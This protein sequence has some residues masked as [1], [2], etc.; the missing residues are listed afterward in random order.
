M[1]LKTSFCNGRVVWK[2]LTRFAPVWALYSVAAILYVM[3]LGSDF[4]YMARDLLANLG[5]MAIYRF[6]HA[7]IVAAC[8]FGD[9]FDSRMCNGL[10]AMPIRRS[11]WLWTN[12]ISGFL[13][14]LIPAL[15]G[16]A[17]AALLLGE[18][19]WVVLIW[20]GT[21]LLFF[22]FFYAVAVFSAMCAGKRLGMMAI[23][24]ILNFA[25]LLVY[26]VIATIYEP[27]LYGVVL[28]TTWFSN[29]CPANLL[30]SQ[31]YVELADLKMIVAIESWNWEAWNCLAICTGVGIVIYALSFLLYCKRKLETAGDFLSF[32]TVR[33][34]FML[35]YTLAV[36]I[37]IFA[38]GNTFQENH[39]YWFLALG[40]TIGYFTGRMLLDRTVKVFRPKVL[41]GFVIVGAL[42]AGSIGLSIWDPLGVQS[43][44]PP[45]EQIVSASL[46][47]EGNRSYLD[48]WDNWSSGEWV[49]MNYSGWYITDPA[50][51]DQVR[52]FHSR[53]VPDPHTNP[54]LTNTVNVQYQLKN[55]MVIR[56]CYEMP[57][58]SVEAKEI[59]DF[60]IA[61]RS[62]VGDRDWNI[63]AENIQK[64]QI[65]GKVGVR[66]CEIQNAQQ[67]IAL[68]E[69]L[70]LDAQAGTII[71]SAQASYNRRND[72]QVAELSV[73]WT[74]PNE[75]NEV[76]DE[77]I[78]IYEDYV[79]TVAFLESLGDIS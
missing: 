37:L 54:V 20:Q 52:D 9:L 25:S 6:I 35:A 57:K 60:L 10:H 61:L 46:Y 65:E 24:I 18:Y 49:D 26:L 1:R 23:Y 34:I 17:V 78:K 28:D 51:I 71:K 76:F 27:L 45:T 70:S 38:F 7:F 75:Y 59:P 3:F 36:G 33:F 32:K 19:A 56:R 67:K 42:L 53:L 13:F 47:P 43:Y 22:L 12:L 74:V 2:N 66:D 39:N 72:V 64:I 21:N 58:S 14:A 15:A 73:F 30:A 16:G 63:V 5:T 4:D 29:L 31:S 50:E 68:L 48:D 55:G 69:A 11:G 79:H 44:I 40:V 8:L 41:I 77:T 62:G